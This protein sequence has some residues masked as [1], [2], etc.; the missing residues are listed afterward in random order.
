MANEIKTI[1]IENRW[2]ALQNAQSEEAHLV[3]QENMGQRRLSIWNLD[4][5]RM[6]Q[7]ESLFFT[8]LDSKGEQQPL[9]TFHGVIVHYEDTRSYWASGFDLTGGGSPPECESFDL[10]MGYGNNGDGIGHHD[11]AS[12][13]QNAWGSGKNETGKAC[14]EVRVFYILRIG[15]EQ[16]MFPS[17][18]MVGPG[19]LGRVMKHFG[20]LSQ[21]TISYRGVIHQ[22]SV[23]P[24][25]SSAGINYGELQ[26][27]VAAR[28]E[29]ASL[30]RVRAYAAGLEQMFRRIRL[31]EQVNPVAR[32]RPDVSATSRQ[33]QSSQAKA[34]VDPA[35]NVPAP[36]PAP[37][38]E[39]MPWDDYAT[40]AT[41]DVIPADADLPDFMQGPPATETK[42]MREPGE[43]EDELR[44]RKDWA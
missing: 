19:S 22:F 44:E 14:R 43:D 17:V 11:C 30:S 25:K 34:K 31:A 36:A 26:L 12:C 37:V 10:L 21:R 41:G 9:K 39:P 5:I 3:L 2:V 18:L 13:A 23:V 38:E 8:A 15:R 35:R 16:D 20:T 33:L 6:P 27:D 40:K 1:G 7:G 4:R 28:L 42:R 32:T 24:G 29:P